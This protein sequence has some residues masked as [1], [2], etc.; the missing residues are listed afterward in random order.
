MS[1]VGIRPYE[2]RDRQAV[3]AIAWE[4]AFMG[5]PA[6]AF[7]GDRELLEDFLTRYFTDFEPESS[8]VA[9]S[10][11]KVV[12]YLIGAVDERRIGRVAA[13]AIVPGLI[14]R[15]LKDCLVS[16][17]TRR[18]I[19]A[20]IASL[21]RGEFRGED[22]YNDYPAV[23]HINLREEVRGQGVGSALMDEYVRHL[24]KK[25]VRGVHLATMSPRSRIFF[26]KQGFTLL[27]LHHRSYFRHITHADTEIRIYGR[28]LKE[29]I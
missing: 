12:G 23:L 18:F 17:K 4:T 19:L 6:D 24:L 28:K 9:E 25:G 22:Y 10:D 8:F 3:R 27:S 29:S 14:G 21:L 16:P 11:A 20:S 7:F 13:R 1:G 2:A 15:L 5:K 26:E